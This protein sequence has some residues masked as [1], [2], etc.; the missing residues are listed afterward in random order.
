MIC[1]CGAKMKVVRTVS[2][3]DATFRYYRCPNCDRKKSSEEK[4]TQKAKEKLNAARN[5]KY[6]NDKKVL[7]N[8]IN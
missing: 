4:V 8:D 7:Q 3:K 6:A 5:K 1:E 2:G